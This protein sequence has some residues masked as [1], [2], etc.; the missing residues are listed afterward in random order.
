M[1]KAQAKAYRA[2]RRVDL[3]RAI[4]REWSSLRSHLADVI[5]CRDKHANENFHAECV[6]DYAYNMSTLATELYEL[7]K[8]DFPKKFETLCEPI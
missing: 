3:A 5:K 7:T 8:Q 1:T 4:D 2:S 6:R